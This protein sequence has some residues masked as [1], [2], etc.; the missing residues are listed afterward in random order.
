MSDCYSSSSRKKNEVRCSN[1][2]RTPVLSIEERIAAKDPKVFDKNWYKYLPHEGENIRLFFRLLLDNL[3]LDTVKKVP[4]KNGLDMP[5]NTTLD[6]F[7][8][9]HFWYFKESLGEKPA[10]WQWQ[11][12]TADFLVLRHPPGKKS[13]FKWLHKTKAIWTLSPE[14]CSRI[15]FVTTWQY[16]SAVIQYSQFLM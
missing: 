16:A 6:G 4:T 7:F 2:R 12:V 10:L 5:S 8:K 13:G 14:Q 1:N 11:K 15:A 3:P 9:N